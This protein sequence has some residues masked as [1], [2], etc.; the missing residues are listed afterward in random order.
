MAW[1]GCGHQQMEAPMAVLS[2]DFGGIKLSGRDADTFVRQVHAG[3]PSAEAEKTLARGREL[4]NQMSHN[5][6]VTVTASGVKDCG[7]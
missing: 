1:Y 3:Q 7:R 2:R 4:L 5:G 6:Q